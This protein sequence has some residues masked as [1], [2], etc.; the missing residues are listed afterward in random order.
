MSRAE[1]DRLGTVRVQQPLVSG[2]DSE[3]EPDIA[4]VPKASYS[5]AHP[6]RAMLVIEVAESSLEHDRDTKG[7]LYALAGV[8][9]Y[10]II[11]VVRRSVEVYGDP[12]N[13]QYA[14][15]T[16]LDV[17][18]TATLASFPDVGVAVRELFD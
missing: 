8:P 15:K 10:W 5:A 11:D 18:G 1:Y 7:S 12:Q 4:I 6:D 17:T 13:G 14:S 2:D 9:E 3:P 16:R